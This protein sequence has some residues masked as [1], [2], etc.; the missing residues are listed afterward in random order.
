[1]FAMCCENSGLTNPGIQRQV[2]I[3]YQ[4]PHLVP[5][6]KLTVWD[7]LPPTPPPSVTTRF[8][9]QSRSLASRASERA[10]LSGW[11]R[12]SIRP[13]ISSPMLAVAAADTRPVRR[14]SFRPL[15][16]S[17]YLPSNRL[18]DLPEFDAVSF[19]EIGEITMPARALLRARSAEVV[20]HELP[21]ISVPVKP[22]SMFERSL[23]RARRDTITSSYADS[24]PSSS[25][26]ALHSH[27]VSCIDVPDRG[28]I[29]P[30]LRPQ[31]SVTI[32]S[33]MREE[34]TP[35]CTAGLINDI[36]SDFPQIEQKREACNSS[37]FEPAPS[38]KVQNHYS[39]RPVELPVD[40]STPSTV[41][42][43]AAQFRTV[44][45]YTASTQSQT[46]V[47][48][49][50]G[51]R[52]HSASISTIGSA[53]TVTS[54]FAEHRKKRS[55]FYMLSAQH[56]SPPRALKLIQ[57]AH[58]RTLTVSSVTSTVYTSD[59]EN[60]DIESVTT[61]SGTTKGANTTSG[62]LA[63]N[64]SPI[65]SEIPELPANYRQI[66]DKLGKEVVTTVREINGPLRSPIGLAF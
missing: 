36:V 8:F 56:A 31:Q 18:S 62:L 42:D 30:S 13:S 41:P 11:G 66:V 24:R 9:A 4:Q 50:L 65:A 38:P 19:T 10:T 51:R 52:S 15:E 59:T 40:P 33:P 26:E 16:L 54:S 21:A 58:R 17:I 22:A 43:S 57:R 27:P 48:Q 32:L 60:N 12:A 53:T 3:M 55:Q 61:C 45:C 49:W 2:D 63:M 1:M 39:D 23:S 44:P 35:P 64:L 14:R 46:R 25:Y 7:E 20:C 37:V 6:M 29:E 5:P 28:R 34:F 47:S